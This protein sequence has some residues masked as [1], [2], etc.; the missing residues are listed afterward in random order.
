M[1]I[2]CKMSETLLG[3]GVLFNKMTVLLEYI[4]ICDERFIRVF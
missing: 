2:K 1:I 3:K 4:F